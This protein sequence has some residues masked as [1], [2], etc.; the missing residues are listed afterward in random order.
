[1]M[2]VVH[3]LWYDAA[4]FDTWKSKAQLA[5]LLEDEPQMCE[6]V[7]LLIDRKNKDKIT[8][9]QTYSPNAVCGLFEIPRGCIKSIKTLCTLPIT[10]EV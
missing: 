8:I 7:G 9:M 10:I 6:T 1:M 4:T 2:R 5:E 3:V